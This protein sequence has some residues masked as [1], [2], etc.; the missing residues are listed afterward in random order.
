MNKTLIIIIF[1][2][3]SLI[4]VVLQSTILSPRDL[5]FLSPDLNLILIITLALLSGL[6]GGTILAFGNGYMLDILSGNFIGVNTLSRLSVFA[7]IRSTT[8]N[9]YYHR[10]PI[11]FLAIFF[12]TIFSWA[13]I[14]IVFK[15]NS[16][17]EIHNS[18][19]EILK[20]GLV[21]VMVGLPLFLLIKK[22]YERVQK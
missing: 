6:K 18:F 19:G 17:V 9:V 20:N 2:I 8:D 10:I 7:I 3:I 4:L 12:S 13:F 22:F 21:N 1:V 16:D 14:W 15:F 5:G 11:L